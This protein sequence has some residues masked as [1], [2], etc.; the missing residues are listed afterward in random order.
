M[1]PCVL[2]Y[3]EGGNT[4]GFVCPSFTWRCT[5]GRE[6][7]APSVLPGEYSGVYVPYIYLVMYSGGETT[8]LPGCYHREG[9]TLGSHIPLSAEGCTQGEEPPAPRSSWANLPWLIC[10]DGRGFGWF[11]P[12]QCTCGFGLGGPW[13]S[14]VC[15]LQL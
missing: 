11:R 15:Q 1:G 10:S 12:L 2:C 9:Y 7:P 13:V 14:G 3:L 5:Q 4:L 6:P 8:S